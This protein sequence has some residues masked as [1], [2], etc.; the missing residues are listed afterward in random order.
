MNRIVIVDCWISLS[1]GSLNLQRKLLEFFWF[2][3]KLLTEIELLE[4][5]LKHKVERVSF[6]CNMQIH[7]VKII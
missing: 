3:P 5:I 4:N 7:G 2:Y 6:S 1:V